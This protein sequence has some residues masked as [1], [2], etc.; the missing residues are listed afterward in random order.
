VDERQ[1]AE[2][3][4][5]AADGGP[6]A[7]FGHVDVVAASRRATARRRAAM[8]G[9][10]AIA[11]VMLVGSIV[12]GG[13]LLRGTDRGIE[14]A[15]PAD[16]DS[17]TQSGP[18]VLG[19]PRDQPPELVPS[20]STAVNSSGPEANAEQGRTAS[21]KVV[22]WPGL[23]DGDARAGCGPVVRELAET[24]ISGLPATRTGEPYAVPDDCPPG[25]E[26]AAV[27]VDGGAIYVVL[28]PVRGDGPPDQQVR[29]GD[30]AVGYQVYTPTGKVLL[31]LSVPAVD[32]G[33]APY[34]DQT[35]RLADTIAQR[36]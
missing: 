10:T 30:G 1:L 22:P 18:T 31:V 17:T 3:F 15:T 6:P 28:G 35:Q 34:A 16:Q 25:A 26:A 11:M 4:R 23:R 2:L 21:G 24:I 27:P 12:L 20:P 32:G 29:R 19:D 8:A 7:S 5:E 13:G 36:Y 33:P 9:G 14:Q